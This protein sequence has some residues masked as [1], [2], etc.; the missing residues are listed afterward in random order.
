MNFAEML[1]KTREAAGLTQIAVAKNAGIHAVTLSHYESGAREP[2]ISDAI[3]IAASL[4]VS[5]AHLLGES[6]PPKQVPMTTSPQTDT[7]KLLD[8]LAGRLAAHY[9]D[10]AKLIYG[11]F[12][13]VEIRMM[14]ATLQAIVEMRAKIAGA[15][16]K[17]A[18]V[19]TKVG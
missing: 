11:D 7:G 10:L 19:D 6:E 4:N 8:T 14:A 2:K 17:S 13:E 3:K 15:R 16:P 1:K 5:L 12:D 9:P 18:G